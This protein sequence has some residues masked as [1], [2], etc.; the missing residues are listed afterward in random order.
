MSDYLGQLALRVQQPEFAVQPRTVSRFESL[1]HSILAAAEPSAPGEADELGLQSGVFILTE[2]GAGK[3]IQQSDSRNR[4]ESE[5]VDFLSEARPTKESHKP[6]PEQSRTEPPTVTHATNT[7]ATH[8]PL[9]EV[10]HPGLS[11][12]PAEQS[13]RI[14]RSVVEQAQPPVKFDKPEEQAGMVSSNPSGRRELSERA[15]R[16]MRGEREHPQSLV[17]NNRPAGTAGMASFNPLKGRELA[18]LKDPVVRDERERIPPFVKIANPEEK[19]ASPLSTRA[20]YHGEIGVD[21]EPSEAE[22]LFGRKADLMPKSGF[23]PLPGREIFKTFAEPTAP[24]LA[25]DRVVDAPTI[26]VTIGRVEIRA[27]VASTP[28]RKTPT[29]SPVMSLDEYFRQRNG[30]RG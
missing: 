12:R 14:A 23:A 19:W 17:E 4:N 7:G 18:E 15:E 1:R 20:K 9:P 28:T 8:Q 24:Q 29:Q 3:P 30:S 13:E 16:S 2:T 21:S 5:T 25:A 22:P 10:A 26:L 6:D 27:T 11:R